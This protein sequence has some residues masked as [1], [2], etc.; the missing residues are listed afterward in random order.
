[1]NTRHYQIT[2]AGQ[3]IE[4][5]IEQNAV[6]NPEQVLAFLKE[7]VNTPDTPE[8]SLREIQNAEL[9][10]FYNIGEGVSL[11]QRMHGGNLK[12]FGSIMLQHLPFYTRWALVEE[13]G[14]HMLIPNNGAEPLVDVGA[15]LIMAIPED[16]IMH[17]TVAWTH[18]ANF[19]IIQPMAKDIYQLP[20]MLKDNVSNCYLTAFSRSRNTCV[21]LPLPNVYDD[22]RL[23]TGGSFDNAF[24]RARVNHWGITT[25]I[26]TFAKCWSETAWNTDLLGGRSSRRML[27]Y[28]RFIRFNADSGAFMPFSGCADWSMGTSPVPLEELYKPWM[29]NEQPAMPEPMEG[30]ENLPEGDEELVEAPPGADPLPGIPVDQNEPMHMAEE[31]ANG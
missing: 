4:V 26:R 3:L 21:R 6:T 29:S 5:S 17:F 15:P 11:F 1:M 10:C 25:S 19:D 27:Q 20:E 7:Q 14:T 24:F 13:E 16:L 2:P 22:A 28:R 12:T 18:G 8:D 31:V 30:E 9:K 23:C